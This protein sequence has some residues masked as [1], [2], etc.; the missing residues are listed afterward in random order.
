MRWQSGQGLAE[1]EIIGELGAGLRLPRTNSRTE[2]AARPHF[3]AQGP[4]QRGTFG[5]TLNDDRAGAFES[6]GRITH[7]LTRLD[8]P[9]SHLLRAL[10]RPPEKHLCQRLKTRFAR[11]LSL[12]PPFRPV[13]QVEIL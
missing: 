11:D 5:E 3:L 7:P 2:T 1:L 4:D 6:G 12:R 13:G 9:A 8:I 10:V